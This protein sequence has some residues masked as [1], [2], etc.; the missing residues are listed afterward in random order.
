MTASLYWYDFETTGTDSIVDRPLQF[1][2]LRTDLDLEEIAEPQNF[3]CK[4]GNDV[5]PQPDAL[6]VTGIMMS[7]IE[8]RGI[9]ER[10]FASRILEEFSVPQT[11]VAGFNNL[12]F[13][14]EF[15]R[16]MLYRNFQDPYAREWRSGNS[17]W[18]VI[19]LFRTA[20]A[21]RPEGFNWPERK[22]G[23]PS[24]RLEDLARANG[25]PHLDAH[26]A[27]ADVRATIEVTRR[28]RLAQPR[29]YDFLFTLRDK[30][31]VLQQL[32]PLGKQP[33]VHVSSMYPAAK[34]C[35]AIVL[36]ICQH[37]G[38]NNGVIAFDLSQA[39]SKLLDANP[40]ELSRL[41]FSKAA[42]LE[43]SGDDRVALK[44]IHVNRCPSV[45]PLNTLDHAAAAR[46]GIDLNLCND[47]FSELK[48]VS[49][50]VEKIQEAYALNRFAENDDPDFQLYSGGFFSDV[51]RNTMHA[52]IGASAAQ[53]SGFAGKFQD[54][55]LDEMLFR[56][57]AR[58]YPEQL[59]A[60]ESARWNEWRRVRWR[61]DDILASARRRIDE[62]QASAVVENDRAVLQDLSGYLDSLEAGNP[63]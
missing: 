46:L 29:L 3:L 16:Q 33:V 58:N 59:N 5:I 40:A 7:D 10:D 51:D 20:Y 45:A 1:A 37:P 21:L 27:L 14:D 4:P 25:L 39:T 28:L 62:L 54:D 12:R 17:R 11:C 2:G 15:T 52:V 13:D 35:A 18:D 63:S 48:G 30:K 43:A 34:G 38:N 31:A 41:I 8:A 57:K 42:E 22:T 32:Y 6:L 36:P 61:E 19:D 23:V 55:R 56:L 49:G 50:L 24:F 47:R 60:E 26:D 9:C 44:T 53:L